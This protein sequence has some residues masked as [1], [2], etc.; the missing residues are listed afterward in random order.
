MHYIYILKSIKHDKHYVGYTSD[1]KR[2]FE[3]HNLGSVNFTKKYK[4]WRLVYYE[5]YT[6][7][8]LARDRER[9]LKHHGKAWTE[10]KKRV[11]ES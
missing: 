10:I 1:L 7:E 11:H 6:S 2:R 9:K 5:A 8:K 4:P 3:Q